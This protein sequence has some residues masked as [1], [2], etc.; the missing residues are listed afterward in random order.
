MDF[1]VGK[2]LSFL[3]VSLMVDDIWSLLHADHASLAAIRDITKMNSYVSSK[4]NSVAHF[5]ASGFSFSAYITWD[6]DIPDFIF[7][8]SLKDLNFS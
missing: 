2:S 6:F 8:I 3:G 1:V 4:C 5:I 7:D